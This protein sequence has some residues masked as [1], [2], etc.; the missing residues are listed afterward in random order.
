MGPLALWRRYDC[1]QHQY[2]R[3]RYCASFHDW[4]SVHLGWFWCERSIQ[5]RLLNVFCRL[6]HNVLI[7]QKKPTA[8]YKGGSLSDSATSTTPLSI[9]GPKVLRHQVALILPFR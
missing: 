7:Q 1:S 3:T 5:H 4:Q 9:S 2:T 8:Y 6:E